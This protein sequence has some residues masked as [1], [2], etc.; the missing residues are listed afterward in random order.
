[1]K[2]VRSV[3]LPSIQEKVV[4]VRYERVKDTTTTL[5]FITM[6]N[7]HLIIGK[8]AC[9]DPAK[10]N[11]ALGEKYAYEDAINQIWPL[12]GYLLAED[13]HREENAAKVLST[14][15]F[16]KGEDRVSDQVSY[17]PGTVDSLRQQWE[18]DQRKREAA[19]F[20]NAL[21]QVDDKMD[22]LINPTKAVPKMVLQTE[23]LFAGMTYSGALDYAKRGYQIYRSGWNGKGMSVRYQ[24][25]DEHSKMTLPYTYLEYTPCEKYPLGACVPWVPSQTDQLESDWCVL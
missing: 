10:Y 4:S 13:I 5:C 1:M 19:A 15:A 7:G 25:P 23:P 3:T 8:A 6:R 12:E 22:K 24:Q 2:D 16:G 20:G 14:P 18:N 21:Q 11:V 17:G 9:V